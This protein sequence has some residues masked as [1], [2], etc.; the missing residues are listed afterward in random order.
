M[1]VWKAKNTTIYNENFLS[2]SLP[3]DLADLI[4]TSPPYN[5]GINY[6]IYDDN[7]NYQDYLNFTSAWMNK[8]ISLLKDSGRICVNVP[9][10]TGRKEKQTLS[11]DVITIAKKLGLR[12]KGTIIWNKQ[13]A[14][15]KYSMV[16]SKNLETIIVFYKKDWKPVKKIYKD[17]VNEI[18]TFA[19]ESSFKIGHPAPFPIELPR[20]LIKMFTQEGET[21]M[22]PFLGSGTTLVACCQTKRRGIGVEISQRYSSLA[23]KR[24]ENSLLPKT[25]DILI[26]R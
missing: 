7:K 6:E 23:K 14:R 20:R 18:W 15:N 25:S 2:I 5:I 10:D 17:Y 3:R 26:A 4:I 9:I 12:Y 21:V 22:D 1:K 8:C 13:N 24:V 16:F 11:A 19:G